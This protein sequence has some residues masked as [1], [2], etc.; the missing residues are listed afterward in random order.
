MGKRGKDR[1]KEGE[2][3]NFP[4]EST[5]YLL[6]PRHLAIATSILLVFSAFASLLIDQ[7]LTGQATSSTM[8]RWRSEG[9]TMNWEQFKDYPTTNDRT[10]SGKIIVPENYHCP[11]EAIT[12]PA[13][14]LSTSNSNNCVNGGKY[15]NNFF[16]VCFFRGTEGTIMSIKCLP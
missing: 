8:Q 13:N 6:S 11:K 12:P 14:F 1:G 9:L 7:D 3:T 5:P 10:P 4:E 16:V 15:A 2:L